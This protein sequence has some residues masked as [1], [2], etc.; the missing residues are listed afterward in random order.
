M[1]SRQGIV[2][3]FWHDLI[4]R[5]KFPSYDKGSTG[6]CLC[7]CVL[8][9]YQFNVYWSLMLN[10]CLSKIL[11]VWGNYCYQQLKVVGWFKRSLNQ[12]IG[13]FSTNPHFALFRPDRRWD[14]FGNVSNH[15][16]MVTY[17][18][19]WNNFFGSLIRACTGS[20]ANVD[21]GTS[22]LYIEVV[23]ILGLSKNGLW[24][25]VDARRFFFPNILL[26]DLF[27]PEK[28]KK[29]CVQS[30][31]HPKYKSGSNVWYLEK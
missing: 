27:Y 12:S 29:K 7:K 16:G 24:A 13:S 15:W 3:E 25:L 30:I 9:Y 14:I 1:M 20:V 18:F 28:V 10:F 21:A 8:G 26:F 11:G 17:T 19:F 31:W 4:F 2:W 6:L 5:L 22:P 23:Q